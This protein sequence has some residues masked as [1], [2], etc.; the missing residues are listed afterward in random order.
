MEPRPRFFRFSYYV[1]KKLD[2]KLAHHQ[3]RDGDAT[4]ELAPLLFE[5]GYDYGGLLLNYPYKR[6]HR[7]EESKKQLSVK[8]PTVPPEI[9]QIDTSFLSPND[10]ILL[11]TRPP[12]DDEIARVREIDRSYTSLEVEVLA[13][14]RP[15]LRTSS[16]PV[17]ALPGKTAAALHEKYADRATID[18][19]D[20]S[21]SYQRLKEYD[22][23]VSNKPPKPPRTA[24]FLIHPPKKEG[25]P[26]IICTFGIGGNE[27]LF[28]AHLLRKKYP[29]K[30]YIKEPRF[31]MAEMEAMKI[32]EKPTDLSFVDS[33]ELE[34]IL[35]IPLPLG[36]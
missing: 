16:R 35:D 32:P 12:L 29:D 14:L 24:F 1:S 33:W 5:K 11:T 36:D 21:A 25:S 20:R 30:F 23:I 4:L 8:L 19:M 15:Y 3:L 31:V 13:A 18:F 6:D 27:S 26:D 22:A 28:W 17:M 34:F 10:L 2:R 7:V 9:R